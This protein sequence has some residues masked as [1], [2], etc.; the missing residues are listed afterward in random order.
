MPLYRMKVDEL[1]WAPN[2]ESAYQNFKDYLKKLSE[3]PIE[4]LEGKAVI[5]S[6]GG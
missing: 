1:I 3:E 2:Q 4:K 5:E 6:C